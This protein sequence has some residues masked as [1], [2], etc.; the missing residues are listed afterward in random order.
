MHFYKIRDWFLLLCLIGGVQGLFAQ[1]SPDCG[2]AIPI[3]NNTPV[4]GGTAG[5]GVDD[6]GGAFESGCLERTLSGAIESNSAWY[7]FRTGAS[8]QLGFTI[9]F[10][11]LEDWDFALYRASDCGSLGTPVRCNFFDNQDQKSFMGVGEDPTGDTGSLQYE[12]WLDVNAGEDYYL[13]IN[14]FSNTNS[15]FS[16]QF[17]GQIFE[18]H[19]NDA[20]DCSIVNN[21]LGPPVAACQGDLVPLDATTPGAIEYRWF[22]DTGSGF[23]LL[24]GEVQPVYW[25]ASDALYRVQ[26]ILPGGSQIISDVQIGF[27]PTPIAGQPTDEVVCGSGGVFDLVTKNP[28]VLGGQPASDFRVSYHD[29]PGDA[30]SGLHPLPDALDLATGPRTLYVRLTS[31][32]NPDCY[33]ATVSFILEAV[34]QPLLDFPEEVFICSQGGNA[35]IGLSQPESGVHYEW[36]SGATSYTQVVTSPGTYTLTATRT[37]SGLDCQNTRSVEVVASATPAIDRI[38]VSDLQK[39]NEIEIIPVSPG[40]FEYAL[41]DGPFQ[42][43]PLFTGVPPGNHTLTMRD[44]LGC[45]A[46]SEEVTVVGFPLFFTPNGDGMNDRWEVYGM[47]QLTDPVLLIFDRYGKLLHQLSPQSPAWDGSYNGRLLPASDYWFRL[48]YTDAGGQRQTA[49]FLNAHFSLKR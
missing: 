42:T 29:T 47:E 13:L 2:T 49:R 34:A 12:P 21:L 31:V 37:V 45:G 15:G 46:I 19:P 23:N 26:V 16:I 17:T 11:P 33:D 4:N 3:C 41:N 24:A 5:Y 28:E 8:G 36:D 44:T 14:N 38:E 40:N 25:A 7:R 35:S 39:N 22:A 10:D 18:S 20:L 27:S 6:F 1:V 43:S 48:E 32:T 9:G 30:Q